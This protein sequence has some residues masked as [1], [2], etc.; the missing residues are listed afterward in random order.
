M[1]IK[2]KGQFTE[3]WTKEKQQILSGETGHSKTFVSYKRVDSEP[4]SGV[5]YFPT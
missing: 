1:F 5:L 3:I 2:V 4:N